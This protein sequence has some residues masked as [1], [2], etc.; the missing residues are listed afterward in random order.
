MYEEQRATLIAQ[1]LNGSLWSQR[2]PVN[3]AE[4][5]VRLAHPRHD[6]IPKMS[7][8]YRIH[9]EGVPILA[10]VG[11][12]KDLRRRLNE[13]RGVDEDLMPYTDP[14]IAGP[15]LWAWRQFPPHRPYTVTFATFESSAYWRQGFEDLVI[16]YARWDLKRDPTLE[17]RWHAAYS[18]LAS[19]HK[20]PA[21]WVSSS[22]RSRGYRGG[23]SPFLSECHT[24][25]IAPVGDLDDQRDPVLDLGWGGHV[26]SAWS[27]ARDIR[28][29]ERAQG[30]YR[31][32]KSDESRLLFIGH[33]SLEEAA[34]SAARAG[35][36]LLFSY[37]IGP[38]SY[39]ERLELLTDTI[40]LYLCRTN[41][42]PLAQYG[43]D[44]N[45]HAGSAWPLR[46][47][48]TQAMAFLS[49]IMPVRREK[50]RW[51]DEKALALLA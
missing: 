30:L 50:Q 16:A 4:R 10:Y 29:M 5:L 32:R 31:L 28:D 43:G 34:R 47:L 6:P 18:P 3:R 40:G 41:C 19:F 24:P 22:S 9:M 11:Q 27:E 38:W 33:G 25:S 17:E 14:H 26:W 8:I 45:Q 35:T 23:P 2:F 36:D 1:I 46:D 21:G 44:E 13:L 51:W 49:R 39:H 37:A 42:L 12:S 7:G 48:T 15:A 20:M